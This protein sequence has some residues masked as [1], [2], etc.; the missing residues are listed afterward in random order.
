M[1]NLPNQTD[2]KGVILQEINGARVIQKFKGEPDVELASGTLKAIFVSVPVEDPFADIKTSAT[3]H[4]KGKETSTDLWLAL[5]IGSDFSMP[6]KSSQTVIPENGNIASYS[7]PSAEIPDAAI[8]LIFNTNDRKS[9]YD[10]EEILSD[11]CAFHAFSNTKSGANNEKAKLEL[12]DDEGKL[13]GTIDGPWQ[14]Q[15]DSTLHKP[16]HEKDPVILELPEEGSS[17]SQQKVH[18]SA[19]PRDENGQLSAA[20]QNDWL[21]RGANYVSRSLEMGSQWAGTKMLKAADSYVTRSTPPGSQPGSRRD[22]GSYPRDELT[23]KPLSGGASINTVNSNLTTSGRTAVTFSPQTHNT[24]RQIRNVSGKVTSVSNRTTSAILSAAS[25]VGDQIG[26]RTGIQQKTQPD[27]T[28]QN[29]KGFRGVLNRSLIAFNVVL[30]GVT[31]SA[32]RLLKD[33]GEASG[34]VIEHRYGSEAKVISG[35]VASVGRSAFIVY[36]DINGVRRKALLRVATGT[37]KAR[38]PDGSEVILQQQN[39]ESSPSFN[40]HAQQTYEKETEKTNPPGYSVSDPSSRSS[41]D[42]KYK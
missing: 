13:L 17:S 36:K 25:N 9:L 26:K 28:V 10:F 29:P 1:T 32:E 18:V 34:R 40:S 22:S 37:I 20:Y 5:E 23:E 3:G 27:G 12:L 24:A 6:I 31:N 38:A 30:D 2:V 39:L 21:L 33:G 41:I 11:Y 35:N 14:L 19:A 42:K 4:G 15:E 16:G 8:Q 7:F